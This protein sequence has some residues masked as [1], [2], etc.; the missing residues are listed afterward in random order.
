MAPDDWRYVIDTN[1]GGYLACTKAALPE[2]EKDGG[3]IILVGSMNADEREAGSSVYVATKAASRLS[4]KPCARR[5]T[6]R[7]FT[8]V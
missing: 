8:F 7:V 4:R 5:S 2:L 6:R 3:T 1:L